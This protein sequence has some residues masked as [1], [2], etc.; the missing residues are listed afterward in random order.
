MTV[1]AQN[2]LK[3]KFVFE[4]QH[5]NMQQIKILTLWCP[6]LTAVGMRYDAEKTDCSLNLS[7]RTFKVQG[8]HLNPRS[9]ADYTGHLIP[10]PDG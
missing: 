6:N 8:L 9:F 10:A 2:W 3:T 4:I 1:K 5:S 7:P